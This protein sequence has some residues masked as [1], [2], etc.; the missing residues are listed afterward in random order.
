[1]DEIAEATRFHG[2]ILLKLSCTSDVMFTLLRRKDIRLTQ[3]KAVLGSEP[4]KPL[5][6]HGLRE[7][8]GQIRVA[9]ATCEKPI[10]IL[11]RHPCTTCCLPPFKSASA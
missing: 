1:M 2:L 6:I 8:L 11:E 7:G 4:E 10:Q 5:K 9:V 3:G